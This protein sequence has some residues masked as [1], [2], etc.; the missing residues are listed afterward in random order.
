MPR[1][2]DLTGQRFGRLTALHFHDIIVMPS[3]Q[4]RRWWCRCSC[5]NEIPVVVGALRSGNTNSCGCRKMELARERLS[6]HKRAGSPIYAVWQTMLRRCD[7][8]RSRSY[9]DYGGRGI[10]VCERWHSF[11][12]F[13]SDM[14]ERPSSKHTIER[15]ENS[16]NYDLANCTWLLRSEQN[17]N[18]RRRIDNT[19]GTT[20]V[21]WNAS[22]G[23]W[24]AFIGDRGKRVY[25]GLFDTTEEAIAVR[26]AAMRERGF[27]PNHG[28]TRT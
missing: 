26:T 11:E 9:P 7:N 25:L 16:G 12:N 13:L 4:H 6:T 17:K 15:I 18:Q 2:L 24:E 22:R 14:G 23:R 19:S 1:I 8:P 20:G 3:T 28:A 27:N 5:G 10:T 21:V